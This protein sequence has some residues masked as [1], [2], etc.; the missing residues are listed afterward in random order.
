M[1]MSDTAKIA[2]A[3]ALGL[4]VGAALWSWQIM[5]EEIFITRV[6]AMAQSCL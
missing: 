3:A 5:G 4:L 2:S 6:M 1:V